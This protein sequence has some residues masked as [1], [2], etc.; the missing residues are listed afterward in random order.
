MHPREKMCSHDK[1]DGL[2]RTLL[3]LVNFI[4]I[5]VPCPPRPVL[6]EVKSKSQWLIKAK[7]VIIRHS[8]LDTSIV[9]EMDEQF[10]PGSGREE[11]WLKLDYQM[12]EQYLI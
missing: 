4:K 3:P 11:N 1:Y 8:C 9:S 7:L 2:A 5:F 12:K 10:F 6:E